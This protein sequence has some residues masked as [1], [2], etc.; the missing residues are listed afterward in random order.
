MKVFMNRDINKS[1]KVQ[2]VYRMA[3]REIDLIDIRFHRYY[4]IENKNT[5]IL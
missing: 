2:H 1:N 3:Y 4:S 5:D